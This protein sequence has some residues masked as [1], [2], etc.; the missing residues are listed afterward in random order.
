MLTPRGK[1]PLPEGSEEDGT[2]NAASQLYIKLAVSHRHSKVTLDQPVLVLMPQ[3][4]ASCRVGTR[5]LIFRS[6]V[7]LKWGEIPRSL[8]LEPRALPLDHH[9]GVGG[10]ERTGWERDERRRT[11]EKRERERERALENKQS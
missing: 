6:L 4:L 7:R 9:G 10:R 3:R 5:E 8:A 11:G 1:S 2:H